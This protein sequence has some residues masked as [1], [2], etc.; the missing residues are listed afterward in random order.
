[1]TSYQAESLKKI[2]Q[3]APV[4]Y[5]STDTEAWQTDMSVEN[6]LVFYFPRHLFSELTGSTSLPAGRN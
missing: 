2:S 5:D 1:M 6:V 3:T 4:I